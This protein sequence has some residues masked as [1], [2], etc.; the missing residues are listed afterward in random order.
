MKRF[1]VILILVVGFFLLKT[2]YQ[3]GQ[4]KSIDP[5]FDGKVSK[6][7]TN[8]P[9]PEDLQV[10]HKTGVLFISSAARRGEEESNN[11]GIY[12]LDLTSTESPILLSTDYTGSFHPHGISLLR[13]DSTLY[14][15]AINHNNNGDYVEKF[16]FNGSSLE[17]IASYS[18][19]DICCPN[20]LVAIDVDKF[21]VSNDHGT[22]TGIMRI[23]EDYIRMPRSALFYYDGTSF[24]KAAG[25]F[26][27]AN[28]VNVSN[29]KNR[30]Y[31]TTTTGASIIT[32]DVHDDGTLTR[33]GTTDL[34]TG[35]DNIDVDEEG[36]LWIG[37]HPKLLDFVS[38]AKD[39]TSISPAQILKLTPVDEYSYSVEEIYL[40]DGNEISGSS[41]GIYYKNE[42]FIGVVLDHTLLRASLSK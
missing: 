36:N 3:A 23:L 17:H 9:G 21:Y 10:D 7:Y 13:K 6:I 11:D 28:G 2:F 40:N 4:F 14:I 5:H 18:A 35:V 24:T 29:D 31:L 1:L 32:F 20:D 22:K 39:S 42:L 16:K 38:H 34:G 15:F 30:L 25:P 12:I 27:Y 37:A 33:K 8:M 26:N 19:P 41:V